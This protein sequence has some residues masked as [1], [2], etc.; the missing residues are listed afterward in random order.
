MLIL[1]WF[2][3]K[4]KYLHLLTHLQTILG[5]RETHFKVEKNVYLGP[6]ELEIEKVKEKNFCEKS[7]VLKLGLFCLFLRCDLFT[8]SQPEPRYFLINRKLKTSFAE[9]IND[10]AKKFF[11]CV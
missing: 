6:F 9:R 11:V 2:I 3:L 5:P 1:F 7:A 8:L 4:K 10:S